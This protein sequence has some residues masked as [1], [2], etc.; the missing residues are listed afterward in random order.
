MVRINSKGFAIS[1]VV[2]GISIM[3]VLIIS[4][5][6]GT[7]SA[8]RSN[9]RNLSKSIEDELNRF[10]KTDTSFSST[11][12]AKPVS[13]EYIVPE[14]QSG[15]Y[16]IELWGAQGGGNGGLGAYTSGV[17]KLNAGDILYFYI[18]KKGN[19]GAS[20]QSSDVRIVS[21]DYD[22]NIRSYETRIMVAAG[23]GSG[24]GA[25]GG[26]L[27][28]Y[29]NSMVAAGGNIRVNT[30]TDYEGDYNLISGTLSGLPSNYSRTSLNHTSN[31]TPRPHA[32]GTSGGDGYVPSSVS[33][34]GG[35]S[36]I[37]GYAG[38]TAYVKGALTANN[39]TYTYYQYQSGSYASTGRT[40]FFYDG[41]M[42]PGVNSGNGRAKIA[43]MIEENDETTQLPR[44]NPK[45][46]KVQII[47]DCLSTANGG[48]ATWTKVEAISTGIN[49]ANG[50]A[51][52]TSSSS[53]YTCKD[54]N[55]GGQYDLD[56]LAI[57]HKDGIDYQNHTISV[58]HNNGS[59]MVWEFLKAAGSG[60]VFSETENV[61]GSRVSA[62]QPD[63]T[64][65]LPD[66][67][68]YY[69]A[70]VLSE[71][72][73]LTAHESAEDDNDPITIRNLN[74][75]RRQ[76]WSIELIDENLR[77]AQREYKIIE[78]ARQKS[79]SI[80]LDENK[81][82]NQVRANTNFNRNRRNETEIWKVVPVGNGTYI[83]ESVVHSTDAISGIVS[84]NYV[85]P[86]TNSSTENHNRIIL[87]R[88][89][90]NTARYKLVSLDY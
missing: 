24:A 72:K 90:K 46:N 57:W 31:G 48:N 80:Y 30:T 54:I 63:Y 59:S 27:Y 9:T 82:G 26:T 13:Q 78:L 14:G 12:D 36:F 11:N 4:I 18:G 40:Y 8:T 47:R 3:G 79:L 2:Y 23:G 35:T 25:A 66:S 39:P 52:T 19:V 58:Y 60:T 34:I 42:Y 76:S 17:I 5:L 22:T 32:N 37:S 41:R 74:G 53:G 81:V 62:Y 16:K 86:Q 50:K 45:M 43:R 77:N 83:I 21:G 84:G 88:N 51:L 7:M 87:G 85:I 68:N 29:N 55:L 89:N 6:M 73:V 67:G 49:V 44:K 70:P 61:T 1:T 38:G 33:S 69:I 15:W 75:Y 10:S 20:G 56:E 65:N 71:N 64:V 28:G